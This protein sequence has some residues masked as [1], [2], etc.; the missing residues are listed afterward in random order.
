MEKKVKHYD[1]EYCAR[2]KKFQSSLS[3]EKERCWAFSMA[4]TFSSPEDGHNKSCL[5]S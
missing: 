2:I 3:C 4:T 5:F 1:F